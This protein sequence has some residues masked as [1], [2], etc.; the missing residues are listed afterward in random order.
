MNQPVVSVLMPAFNA[1]QYIAQA[2][3]SIL[4]QSFSNFELIILNDG[5][6]DRTS[7]IIGGFNDHRIRVIN[8]AENQGLVNAR[9]RLVEGAK[10]RYIA[11][12]DADDIA[13]PSRLEE[14]VN[15]LDGDEADLCGSAY[16][17][18]YEGLGRTKSS[19]ER[20]TD[21][22][23]RALITISSPL[24]NPTVMG[25]AEIFKKFP[26]RVGKDY[27]EDYSLWVELALAGYRFANLKAKLITYRIHVKQTSQVQNAETNAIF[28]KSREEY[29]LGLGILSKLSPRPMG[30]S[31]RLKI[32]LPFLMQLNQK[33]KG[34]SVA[35]NYEIYARFQYRGNGLLTPFTRLERLLVSALASF[36]A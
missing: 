29:L 2:V 35:A 7:Q 3:E 17:S 30:F 14:Q 28:S 9:N 19:K 4:Q 16:Y 18:L 22:D 8:L 34:I 25:K 27:A 24:C 31:D 36:R 5:S 21:A 10:G 15:Y 12:L 1:E 20:Y 6:T 23:I 11:F 32:A 13:M 33:I 26:Y